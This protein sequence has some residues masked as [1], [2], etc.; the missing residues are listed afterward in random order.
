MD[1]QTILILLLVITSLMVSVLTFLTTKIKS[2]RDKVYDFEMNQAKYNDMRRYYESILEKYNEKLMSHEE[3]WKD[4]NHLLLNQNKINE[5]DIEPEV[6]YTNFLLNHGIQEKEL[7]VDRYTAFLLTSFDEKYKNISD[8]IKNTCR[9]IGLEC[10]RGDEEYVAG[11][12]LPHILKHIV[13]ARIIIANIDGRNPN[14][15]YELGIA[16]ALGKPTILISKTIDKVPFDIKSKNIIQYK[17]AYDLHQ[18]LTNAISR[19]IL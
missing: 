13:K 4:V 9:G 14:V 12:L 16:H 18:K 5:K 15:Y 6:H 8:A 3:R 2:S 11:D 17:D 7:E 10:L 19:A 1:T